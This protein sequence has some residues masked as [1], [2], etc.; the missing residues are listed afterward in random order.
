MDLL[1]RKAVVRNSL[2]IH[3]RPVE[4]I[5]ILA[6]EY[7]AELF[8]EWD[9]YM[10]N[11]KSLMGLLTITARQGTELTLHARGHEAENA[12]QALAELIE[13]GFGED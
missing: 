11:A 2:G 10:I 3:A 8:I 7:E 13:N 12:L 6:L 5:V 1:S 9:G 4:K